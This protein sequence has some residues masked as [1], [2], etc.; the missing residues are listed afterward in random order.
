MEVKEKIRKF[1]LK[2]IVVFDE[3][4]SVTLHDDDDIFKKGYVNSLF[5]MKLLGFIENEFGFTV[6]NED[7]K[8]QNFSTVHNIVSLIEKKTNKNDR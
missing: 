5:G 6:E 7:I 8:L 2:N 4:S 3:E 1:I